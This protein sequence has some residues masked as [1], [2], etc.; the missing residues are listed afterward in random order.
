MR[1]AG[2]HGLLAAQPLSEAIH[3]FWKTGVVAGNDRDT[4]TLSQDDGGRVNPLMV[5]SPTGSS[6]FNVHYGADPLAGFHLAEVFDVRQTTAAT[7]NSLAALAKSQ[8]S[9]WCRVF[10]SCLAVNSVKI[11]HHCGDAVNFSHALQAIDSSNAL[12]SFTYLYIR[13]WSAAPLELPSDMVTKYDIIDTSNVMD[14]VGL[15]NLLIAVVSLLS[16][17]HNS[18][19][20]TENLLQ[21]AKESEKGLETLLHSDITMASL[22]FGVAPVGYLLGKTTDCTHVEQQLAV[23]TSSDQG[24][25]KQY[26]M[27][28]PWR[29]PLQGDNSM[30]SDIDPV[31]Y[32]LAMDPHELASFFMQTYLA[33]FREAEDISIRM[34]VMMRKMT[35][36]LSGDLGFCSRLS[37]VAL[38]TSA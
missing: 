32:R 16:T 25:Q 3:N 8:F 11:M 18:V 14:H 7:T 17:K 38:L 2:A 22:L 26:R 5:V 15:L 6:Q 29:R 36:P 9:G 12:P 13:P 4:S 30:A 10:S 23:L 24:R 37:L 35:Q 28:I 31:L 1:S 27:R 34:E 20:Y 21:S 33:M 19:L